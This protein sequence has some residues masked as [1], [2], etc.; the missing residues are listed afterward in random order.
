M[1]LLKD[2]VCLVSGAGQGLGRAVSLEM[3]AEGAI[4]VL[5]E[6]NA[7]TANSVAAEIT[8]SSGK[9]YTYVL[10]ITDYGRYGEVVP[11]APYRRGPQDCRDYTH[12][13]YINGRPEVMRSTACRNP[14]GT[15]R[16]VG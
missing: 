2:K 1:G 8:G 12:T 4:V 16:N 13:I 3:A 15:W 14:D 5:L 11:M 7:G 6:R 10:D 9:A